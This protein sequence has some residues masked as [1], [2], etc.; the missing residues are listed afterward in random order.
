MNLLRLLS[1]LR[2]HDVTSL[3]VEGGGEL[4]W[5]FLDAGVVDRTAGLRLLQHP[6]PGVEPAHPGTGPLARRLPDR[7]ADQP[8]ADDGDLHAA[9][10]STLPA[11]AAARSTCSR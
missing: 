10:L 2:N 7:A 4:A 11:T 9:A 3:L 5:G 1:Y 8:D 6:R